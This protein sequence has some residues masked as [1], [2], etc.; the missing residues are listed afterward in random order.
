MQASA[1][2]RA[3]NRWELPVRHTTSASRAAATTGRGQVASPRTGPAMRTNSAPRISSAAAVIA[4]SQAGSA[5]HAR[6]AARRS[7]G[8][9]MYRRNA[10]RNTVIRACAPSRGQHRRQLPVP[11]RELNPSRVM[12]TSVSQ[13]VRV[14]WEDTCGAMQKVISA[15]RHLPG[16]NPPGA[17][18]RANMNTSPAA[19]STV[20]GE[21]RT[22]AR[23]SGTEYSTA[24]T[25]PRSDPVYCQKTKKGDRHRLPFFSLHKRYLSG[26][27]MTTGLLPCSALSGFHPSFRPH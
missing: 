15:V 5:A 20:P 10:H 14:L 7:G 27:G 16:L 9:A 23:C 17:A 11:V 21:E 12:Y 22:S 1:P 4:R 25:S 3:A 24:A 18:V 2:P 8:P 19:P 13:V 6:Q 26:T